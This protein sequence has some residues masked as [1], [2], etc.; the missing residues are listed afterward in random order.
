MAREP[1]PKAEA[2][3]P[4]PP[5]VSAGA[6]GVQVS[7]LQDRNRLRD[8]RKVGES[9]VALTDSGH[10]LRFDATTFALTG[11]RLARR[12][13]VCLGP[14]ETGSFL[15]GLEDGTLVRVNVETL[16]AERIGEVP[17][18]PVWMG[19]RPDNRGLVVAYGYVSERFYGYSKGSPRDVRVRDLASGRTWKPTRSPHTGGEPTTFLLDKRDRLWLGTDHGE[20]GGRLEVIDLQTGRARDVTTREGWSGVFG[21]IELSNGQVWAF[22]GMAHLFCTGAFIARVDTGAASF[23]YDVPFCQGQGRKPGKSADPVTHIIEP[24]K[25][26]ILIFAGN[27]VSSSNLH[28]TSWRRFAKLKLRYEPGRPDAVSNYPAVHAIHVANENPP[29]LV[30][31]TARDG[32][33]GLGRSGLHPH[34]LPE[35]KMPDVCSRG[36]GESLSA[37]GSAEDAKPANGRPPPLPVELA[38]QVGIPKQDPFWADSI[39]FPSPDGRSLVVASGDS[40]G[41]GIRAEPPF[42]L[43]VGRWDGTSYAP[44]GGHLGHLRAHDTFITPDGQLWA[45]NRQGLWQFE[46]GHFALRLAKPPESGGIRRGTEPP[47]AQDPIP[48]RRIQYVLGDREPPWIVFESD[49]RP[50]AYR[51]HRFFPGSAAQAPR[52]EAIPIE[53]DQMEIM[54]LDATVWGPGEVL[55]STAQG[56]FVLSVRSGVMTPLKPPGLIDS[57]SRLSRD[58]HGHLWLGGRGLWVLNSDGRALAAPSSLPFFGNQEVWSLAACRDADVLAGIED[59]SAILASLGQQPPP[60]AEPKDEL[61]RSHT[62]SQEQTVMALIP[63]IQSFDA[64]DSVDCSTSTT[65]E[66]REWVRS[67]FGTGRDC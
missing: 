19:Q 17:G 56:L 66:R 14:I 67:L 41:R 32:Y 48:F 50:L 37:S 49:L 43:V 55:L 20:W 29:R 5:D 42:P 51:L 61:S 23:I 54:V 25:R 24:E 28:L 26:H 27:D 60:A 12:R 64:K 3:Q 45:L 65:E 33:V 21:L 8:S 31:A 59:G 22:G 15:A 35:T 13:I 9:L 2:S 6:P 52:F 7:Y 63:W 4:R 47:L 62:A 16:L 44:L 58:R 39:L 1:P 40:D 18:Q 36:R 34:A 30:L 11:E 53:R 10:L 38:K 57:V 46:A